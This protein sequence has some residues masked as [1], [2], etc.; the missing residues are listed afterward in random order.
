MKDIS[1]RCVVGTLKLGDKSS[2]E[3]CSTRFL[4]FPLSPLLCSSLIRSLS[5]P[6]SA[7]AKKWSWWCLQPKVYNSLGQYSSCIIIFSTIDFLI[8]ITSTEK[9]PCNQITM[10]WGPDTYLT[11]SRSTGPHQRMHFSVTP[12]TFPRFPSFSCVESSGPQCGSSWRC[13]KCT[14]LRLSLCPI[15]FLFS[16]LLIH[17]KFSQ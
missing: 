16:S 15:P 3:C 17:V 1:W 10:V 4:L 14:C 2:D 6:D 5:I 13:T 8:M 12:S 9:F 11:N 7:F